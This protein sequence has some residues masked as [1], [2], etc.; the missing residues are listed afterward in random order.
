MIDGQ[1]DKGLLHRTFTAEH[2]QFL[3]TLLR[4][5]R[6]SDSSLIR[7]LAL[8]AVSAIRIVLSTDHSLTQSAV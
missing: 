1:E 5:I 7:E 3:A 4:P 8:T 6:S 2:C